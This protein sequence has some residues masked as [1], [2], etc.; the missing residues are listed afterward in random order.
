MSINVYTGR[1]K[2]NGLVF[3]LAIGYHCTTKSYCVS[4][5]NP[6]MAPTDG[7]AAP[8]ML[9]FLLFTHLIV[10]TC[11]SGQGANLERTPG[12]PIAVP[13]PILAITADS[14]DQFR[15]KLRLPRFA[16]PTHYE[17]HFHPDLVSS[18]FSGVVSI[19]VFVL[20]PTR[21]LVLNVVE[22]TIDH[23]SIHFK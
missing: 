11:S 9:Q 23:A 2:S 19:N 15:G 7:G 3:M 4:E 13:M 21:F 17:L 5:H 6:S 12:V 22:L 18:T 16:M 10:A 20:A 14:P 8:A 1:D